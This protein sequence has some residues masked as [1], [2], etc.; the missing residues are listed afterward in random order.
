MTPAARVV[1]D[2]ASFSVD[3]GFWYSVP[4]R[5]TADLSVGSIVRIPLSGRRVRGWVV[6]LAERQEGKLKDIAGI[7]GVLPVFDAELLE[8]LRW[9]ARHYVA[10]VSA[11]LAR[12]TPPNLPR[13]RGAVPHVP[14]LET[15]GTALASLADRA[16]G[17]LTAPATAIVSNWRPLEWLTD[18]GPVFEAGRSVLVVSATAAEAS[19]VASA[20][21]SKWGDLV[22]NANG[23]DG[24]GDTAA[25]TA[26]QS[27]PSLLITT[28]K[29]A[30]WHVAGLGLVIALEENRRAMKDRQTPTIHVRDLL[31]TRSRIEGF[32]LVFY[33]PTPGVELLAAGAEVIREG[34]RSWPLV[35]VVDRSDDPPGSG[36][37][38]SHTVAAIGATV[39]SGRNVF[40]FTHRRA[41][42]ASAR[43]A[44]CRNTRVCRSCGRR[45]G[46]VEACPRCGA[47]P[48]PCTNCGGQEFE[49]MGT[50]PER[51]VAEINRRVGRGVAGVHPTDLPVGVGTER[52]LA[53]VDSVAVS[54]GAD[55]DGM[56]LGGG[57][58]TTEEALRQLARLATVVGPESGSRLI[59]Q[60][61]RPESLL[62]TTMRRGNPV[63]YLERVLVE[64]AR[65]GFPPSTELMAVEVR[66][67]TPGDPG[68]DLSAIGSDV[69]LLGPMPVEDGQRWLL[70]GKL[71][72]VKHDLRSVVGRWRD[73]GATVRVDAD[74]IDL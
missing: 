65:E 66:G 16:A 54:V 7:S 42:F 64:R 72:R 3:D 36:F 15:K 2:V 29:G 22:V 56:L 5:L 11:L 20:A 34:N 59:I 74:P 19:F 58:R 41:G 33:G 37:L 71:G 61:S 60:T 70:T 17:G 6:Q 27:A 63:P 26:A 47:V 28:P 24:A 49:A 18:L 38:S 53:G 62:V 55:V 48:G 25:W 13:K 39:E 67:Q 44:R 21:R 43:C 51:L 31:I 9:A 32:N 8:G 57:Y 73:K 23:E 12:A 35:E 46:L 69:T 40:V 10:P 30:A 4:D 52:D 14:S 1:P 45:I 68:A 50:V